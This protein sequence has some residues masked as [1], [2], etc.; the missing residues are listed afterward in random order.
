MLIFQKSFF[1]FFIGLFLVL[2]NS[3]IL[4]SFRIGATPVDE[5]SRGKTR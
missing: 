4:A 3:V 1:L 5:V 2:M